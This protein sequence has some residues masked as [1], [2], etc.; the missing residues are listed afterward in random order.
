MSSTQ[1]PIPELSEL[2]CPHCKG[3]LSENVRKRALQCWH[4]DAWVGFMDGKVQPMTSRR[5]GA[6]WLG[7]ARQRRKKRLRDRAK[8]IVTLPGKKGALFG[9]IVFS[10]VLLSHVGI[11]FESLAWRDPYLTIDPFVTLTWVFLALASLVH[12]SGLGAVGLLSLIL[13][14][15]VAK[16]SLSPQHSVGNYQ[17]WVLFFAALV[18]AVWVKLASKDSYRT[19]QVQLLALPKQILLGMIIGSPL[20]WL[21]VS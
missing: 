10:W 19:I 20:Y 21:W 12:L 7:K 1:L 2:K 5:I 9:G 16:F 13:W 11:V 6:K 8:G 14:E 17:F 3:A 18:G 4:C 15:L